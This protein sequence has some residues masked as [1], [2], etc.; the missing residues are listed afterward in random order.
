[1]TALRQ[2]ARGIEVLAAAKPEIG[3]HG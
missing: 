2:I 1:V 3:Q